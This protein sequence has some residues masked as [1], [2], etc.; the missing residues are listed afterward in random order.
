MNSLIYM[1][2]F[3]MRFIANIA[4][5]ALY[6]RSGNGAALAVQD[7]A[8]VYCGGESIP[9][10]LKEILGSSSLLPPEEDEFCSYIPL[11]ESASVQLQPV[12]GRFANNRI[13]SSVANSKV[14]VVHKSTEDDEFLNS[15]GTLL[16]PFYDLIKLMPCPFAEKPLLD[17]PPNT[18]LNEF[19]VKL[20][21]A[22]SPPEFPK[23]SIV[24]REKAMNDAYRIGM[25]LV[26]TLDIFDL[27]EFVTSRCHLGE[28]SKPLEF[29]SDW[30]LRRAFIYAITAFQEKPKY[31]KDTCG[32]LGGA[33]TN[34]YYLI[35][36]SLSGENH[37][38]AKLTA[39]YLLDQGYKRITGHALPGL[40][41]KHEE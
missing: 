3:S 12:I 8:H 36:P 2:S 20:A 41:G 7:E 31:D 16:L 18:S 39:M 25:S 4:P 24:A 19:H 6:I 17:C 33:I 15:C 35:D 40:G 28:V 14:C 37:I 23:H 38:Q 5:L 32:F 10:G 13:K 34:L 21:T 1:C 27:Y 30:I 22:L 9:N 26:D 11:V 29:G